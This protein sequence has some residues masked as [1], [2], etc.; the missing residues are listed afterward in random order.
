MDGK[1]LWDLLKND[2]HT[3]HMWLCIASAGA[4]RAHLNRGELYA[5]LVDVPSDAVV[6]CMNEWI[7]RAVQN[8]PPEEHIICGLIFLGEHV[9]R[10]DG[11]SWSIGPLLHSI[12]VQ[13]VPTTFNAQ[14][15]AKVCLEF[16]GHVFKDQHGNVI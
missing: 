16:M 15:L 1:E 6:D 13:D 8:D 9:M 5:K 2:E 4:A 12:A 14:R 11:G 3:R 7:G 10:R